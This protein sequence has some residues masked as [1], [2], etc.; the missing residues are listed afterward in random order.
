MVNQITETSSESWFSRMIGSIKSVLAGGVMFLIAFPL[1]FWNEGRAVTTA[2][3]LEEG[4]GAV[5]SVSPDR[6][7]SA[8]QGKLVHVSGLATTDETVTDP[9]F[10][11]AAGAIKLERK[12]EMYQWQEEKKS[13]EKSKLGGGTETKTTYAYKQA[14]SAKLT[15]SSRFKQPEGH[16][17]PS[18]MPYQSQT[19]MAGKVTLGA[20]ALPVALVEKIVGAEELRVDDQMAEQ[21]PEGVDAVQDAGSF[22]IGKDPKVAQIGDLRV[23]FSVVKPQTVSLVAQQTASTFEPYQS[24][25]GDAILLLQGGTLSAAAMFKA[26]QEEN[27]ILTWILRGLGFMLMFIGMVMVFRP[28]AVFGDVIPLFGSLLG[29]GVGI[30]SFM[31]SAFLSLGTIAVA[32]ILYRPLFAI[33]LLVLGFGAMALLVAVAL[34]ARQAK[35]A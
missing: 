8:N 30:F 9:D 1:L 18:A 17:N 34:R 25:A 6:V 20:F 26:A 3:S 31:I 24:K 19:F 21:L 10:G 33:G 29:A 27:A 4:A 23:R 13:E 15:D 35:A 7:E 22:Y 5:V 16:T 32:W 28:I 12:A 11:V 2:R 14:W